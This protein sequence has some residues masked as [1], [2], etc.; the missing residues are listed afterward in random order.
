MEGNDLVAERVGQLLSSG[1]SV[2]QIARELGL[3]EWR[4]QQLAKEIERRR[5]GFGGT[6]ENPTPEEEAA[7]RASLSLAPE[8]AERA[9]QIRMLNLG[10]LDDR[11]SGRFDFPA[12]DTREE[13]P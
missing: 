13:V 12:E 5:F 10:R 9:E 6:L 4:V 8:V 3:V 11:S 7:S 2:R 1:R